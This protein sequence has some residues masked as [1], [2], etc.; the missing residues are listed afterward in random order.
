MFLK[1]T[2]AQ[3]YEIIHLAIRDLNDIVKLMHCIELPVF[4]VNNHQQQMKKMN[5]RKENGEKY[6]LT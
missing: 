3:T 1:R 6:L 5:E 2:I 4:V